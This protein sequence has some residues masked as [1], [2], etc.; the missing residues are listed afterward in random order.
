MSIQSDTDRARWV[1]DLGEGAPDKKFILHNTGKAPLTVKP[2]HGEP[3]TVPG[4][5]A[6][7]A[8]GLSRLVEVIASEPEVLAVY[9][10]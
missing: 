5:Q 6:V 2:E 7:T 1:L 9:H 3:V 10:G 8:T 4:N